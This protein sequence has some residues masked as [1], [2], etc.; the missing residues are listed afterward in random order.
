MGL[1]NC[2]LGNCAYVKTSNMETMFFYLKARIYHGTASDIQTKKTYKFGV[3]LI[4][5]GVR[6]CPSTAKRRQ[7][8]A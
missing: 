1:N 5:N 7:H 2:G 4:L 3:L 6:I 8:T